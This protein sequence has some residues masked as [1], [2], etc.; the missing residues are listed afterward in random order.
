MSSERLILWF[1]NLKK[2]DVPIVGGK[3]ANLG[4][5]IQAGIPVPPGFA[6]TAQAYKKFIHETGIAQ[7]IYETIERIVTDINNPQLFRKAST[8]V[9]KLIESTPMLPEIEAALKEAYGELSKRSKLSEIFVAVRSSATAEDL[10]GASFAG[11]QETFLNVKGTD[12]LIE[13]TI[14]CWSSLFTPRAIFYRIQ[15]GF[16]HESVYMSV[17]IQKM[18]NSRS[19]GVIFTLDPVTG[20]RNTV[21]IEGSW[22][23]GE[24]VVSGAV[25]PDNFL[26][27]KSTQKIIKKKIEKKKIQYIRDQKTGK[28]IHSEVPINLQKQSSLEDE[29]ILRLA[30]LAT[31]IEKHY[32]GNPQDIEWSIDA[33]LPNSENIFI[34]QS[35]PETVLS[36]KEPSKPSD[37]SVDLTRLNPVIKGLPAS[38]GVYAGKAKVISIISE[39]GDNLEKGDIL[40]TNMT[41]PDWVPYMRMAGAIVTDEGGMTCHAAIVSRELGIPCI[42]GTGNATKVLISTK[43]YTADAKIGVV[44]EGLIEELLDRD[45]IQMNGIDEL[46]VD[47]LVTAT[48]IYVNLSLPEA[49]KRVYE[50]SK[51]DGVGLLRAEHLMLTVGKHP[52]LVIDEDGEEVLIKAFSDG[53]RKVAEAFAP[54]PVLYRFLDFKPDEFLS[55][56]GGEK[57]ELELGHVGPNPAIGYRGCFRYIKEPDVFRA[58]C[59][60][61]RKV[62]EEYGMINVWGMLPFVRTVKEFRLT[63]E[64][65]EEEGLI[66]NQDFKLWIMVEVPSS[67]ILIDKFIEE[68]IDGVSFGTNDFTSLILGL[69]RN[70]ASVQELYDERNL[71]V[72]RLISHVIR[73]CREHG[74]TTSIC[75]Q[76]PSNYP[77]YLEFLVREG[78]TS[79]SVNPDAVIQARLETARIERKLILEEM[80]KT[81]E[82]GKK[83]NILFKPK[84]SENL[85]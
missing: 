79:I 62:R 71:A 77:E 37:S 21:F 54:N 59:R 15:K 36:L 14:K 13:K 17:G 73:V 6:V 11:Q 75:G 3:N 45:I 42:V 52:R 32:G 70:D 23:L 85:K 48:K 64:I 46:A 26:V 39:A 69:D 25:T 18:V 55:L 61:V 34:V 65:M 27:E 49:A 7:E 44:Y 8:K 68:G 74:I 58:E 38:P 53:I 10:P 40:V 82:D 83:K 4:E 66:Q 20:E 57:Y 16:K 78:A 9:R 24:A 60:A 81:N 22:G 31:K 43:E 29:E 51:P 72:L 33:D 47:K 35:R 84:W 12:D 19:A 67:G 63:K 76:A 5:L 41:K 1:E 80:R 28:T 56:P 30:E 2:E 50:S